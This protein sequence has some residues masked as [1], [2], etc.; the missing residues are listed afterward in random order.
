[1]RIGFYKGVT[2]FLPVVG[3]ICVMMLTYIEI[4]GNYD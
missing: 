2:Y 3:I 1:M 4:L